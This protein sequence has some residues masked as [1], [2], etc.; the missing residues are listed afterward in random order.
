MLR[1]ET[2]R[3]HTAAISLDLSYTE[4]GSIPALLFLSSRI[5]RD[6]IS[7]EASVL[8][9]LS[10]IFESEGF[11][12]VDVESEV[13]GTQQTLRI[14]IYKPSGVTFGDCQH[15]SDVVRPILEIHELMPDS[16]NLEVAS[17]GLDRPLVTEADFRRNI[18]RKIQVEVSSST[19]EAS[20]LNGLLKEV[21]AG[22]ILL[23]GKQAIQV[24]ISTI[25]R[26]QIHL[27]W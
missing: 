18:G 25:K 26:A 19:G 8:N 9:L 1:H 27:M 17:P 22:K 21:K 6:D 23:I 12:L 15:I 14:L 24:E 10:P 2:Q 11:E 7:M 20:Q 5:W 3:S 13:V 4:W 16:F